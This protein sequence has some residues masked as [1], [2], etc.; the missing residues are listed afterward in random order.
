VVGTPNYYVQ[1]MFSANRGTHVVPILQN[2]KDIAGEDS[3]YASAA[4]DKNN[5]QLIL[6]LVNAASRSAVIEIELQGGSALDRKAEMDVLASSDMMVYNTPDDPRKI[7]PVSKSI[8]I[9]ASKIVVALDASSLNVL[10][11]RYK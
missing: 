6:K 1:K 7:Y 2:G 3:L 4:V 5:G 10:R 9:D 11:L 8:D